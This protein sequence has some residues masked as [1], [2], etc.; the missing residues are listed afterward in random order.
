MRIAVISHT[1]MVQA[2]R[3]KLEALAR[4][5]GMEVLVVV[6]RSWRSRD[7]G[8]RFLAQ[9]TQDGSLPV[10][11]L[12]SWSLGSG[13]LITYAPVALWRL[14]RRFRP[15]LVH[16]E[17]EPWSLAALEVSLI[18]RLR[19][20]PLTFFSW[21]N[22]DRR[23]LLPFRLI[24][25]WVLRR[26]KAAVAG[27]SEAKS[28]LERHGFTNA[29][30][31]LPQLGI[32]TSAFHP[33]SA[34]VEQGFVVGYVGRLVL[35]KGLLV[36]LQAFARLSPD[37]RLSVV[38]NGPLRN[39]FERRARE[40]GVEG[41]LDIHEGVAHHEVPRYLRRMSVLVLPSLTTPQ[42][43]EQFGHVLVE[44]MASGVPVIGSESGAIPEVVGDAGIIIPEGNVEA[45]AEVLRKLISTPAQRADLAVRGR[46]RVLA[47]YT[48]DSVARRLAAFW[49]SVQ[50]LARVNG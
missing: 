2:N 32:D 25:R 35:Q 29:V 1:Y 8:Q 11:A 44:A 38:G 6:P 7:T 33:D 26:S 14:F 47:E 28:L 24:R 4:L 50:Q 13:S 18:C 27:N 45:L 5:P 42:W 3:G 31:V 41:R 49:E 43:K 19:G 30:T 23:L 17:E 15:A 48:N 21:E 40:L 20:V 39:E 9:S 36:L 22:T 37:I 10:V 34:R 16:L 46:V 12:R